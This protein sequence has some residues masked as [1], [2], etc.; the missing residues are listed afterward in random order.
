M[1]RCT[2][3]TW[4]VYVVRPA[5]G[6]PITPAHTHEPA[7]AAVHTTGEVG[8]A[9]ALNTPLVLSLP[10]ESGSISASIETVSVHPDTQP[11]LAS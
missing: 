7:V 6:E 2:P 1:H 8:S 10:F 11:A 3:A 4:K 9:D 5:T